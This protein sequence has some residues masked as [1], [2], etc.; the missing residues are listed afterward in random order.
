L[1]PE[2]A[3]GFVGCDEVGQVRF[4][5]LVRAVEEAFDGDF[6]DGSVHP[7]DLAIGP[8]M[9]RLG[10]VVFDSVDMGVPTVWMRY[11]TASRNAVVFRISAFSTSST[12]TNSQPSSG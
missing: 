3:D 4:E 9:I 8:G 6:L 5:L 10:E 11:G 2:F 1:G 12:M 7:F